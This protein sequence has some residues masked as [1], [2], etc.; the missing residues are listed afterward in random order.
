MTERG[1]EKDRFEREITRLRAALD[2]AVI[3]REEAEDE[4]RQLRER[5][6]VIQEETIQDR[7]QLQ[8]KALEL[9][10]FYIPGHYVVTLL[11]NRFRKNMKRQRNDSRCKE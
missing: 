6:V 10:V 7:N 3:A 9:E 2:R 5:L 4:A 1:E 11:T 8:T